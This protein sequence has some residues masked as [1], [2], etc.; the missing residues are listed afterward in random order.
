MQRL[1]PN[2]AVWAATT[3]HLWFAKSPS[4]AQKE[5]IPAVHLQAGKAGSLEFHFQGEPHDMAHRGR[6]LRELR[7]KAHLDYDDRREAR[8]SKA[9]I[10][11]MKGRMQVNVQVQQKSLLF[12]CLVCKAR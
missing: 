4:Y 8:L 10:M 6:S 3:T 9:G 2:Y 11:A 7:N 5:L 12:F 1:S